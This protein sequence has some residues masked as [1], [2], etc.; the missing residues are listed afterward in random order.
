[1]RHHPGV[2]RRMLNFKTL[3]FAVGGVAALSSAAGAEPGFIQ[4]DRQDQYSRF[5]LE[6]AY[7]VLDDPLDDVTSLRFDVHG[8]Y[9]MPGGFG[10]YGAM[11]ITHASADGGSGTGIGDIEVGGIFIP[12]MSNPDL[13]LVVHGG[14]TVPIASEDGDDLLANAL[15]IAARP[16]DLVQ[17]IPKGLTLRLG[18]SPIF[19]SGQLF[20]RIDGGL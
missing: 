16:T 20:G 15:G 13:T 9:V 17:I 10:F 5:G 12:R 2:N 19:R 6:A 11:P 18:I 14:V 8:Q 4:M 1:D 3:A 7:L